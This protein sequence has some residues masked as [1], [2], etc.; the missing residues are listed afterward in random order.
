MGE[1]ADMML[2]GT[3]DFYTGEYIGRGKG[4]PRTLDGSLPWE[5]RDGHFPKTYKPAFGVLNYLESRGIVRQDHKESA[6]KQYAA[7]KNWDI[8]HTR[9]FIR[10]ISALITV[11]FG[12]F[13]NWVINYTNT[14]KV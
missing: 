5:Q 4:M 11:N 14:N 1:I 8:P 12:D 3:L 9:K 10:K 6:L 13:K 2:D 7:F